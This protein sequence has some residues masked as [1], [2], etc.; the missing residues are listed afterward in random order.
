MGECENH[1]YQNNQNHSFSSE[2]LVSHIE[3]ALST[4]E[5]GMQLLAFSSYLSEHSLLLQMHSS[6]TRYSHLLGVNDCTIQPIAID[7][8][9]LQHSTSVGRPKMQLKLNKVEL[10]KSCGYIYMES[11]G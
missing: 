7:S 2:I 6:L 4:V 8:Y 11:S 9:T 1:I 3:S 10:L 5:E